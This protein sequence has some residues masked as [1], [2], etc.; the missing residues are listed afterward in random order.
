VQVTNNNVTFTGKKTIKM[1][2]FEVEPPT[3][4]LGTIKT[5]DEVTISFNSK[6][7]K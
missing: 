5:G 2:E 3:A 6:F 4:L 7:N 1:T